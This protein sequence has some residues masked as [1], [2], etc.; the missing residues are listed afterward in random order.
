MTEAAYTMN[1]VKTPGWNV[2]ML[3]ES[4]EGMLRGLT[5]SEEGMLRESVEVTS[6]GLIDRIFVSKQVIEKLER[7]VPV[8]GMRSHWNFGGLY[9]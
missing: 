6:P 4:E 2:T 7:L 3:T 9:R 5:W 1:P 8:Q